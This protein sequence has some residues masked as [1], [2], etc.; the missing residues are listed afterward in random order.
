MIVYG[1]NQEGHM[2]AQCLP[3]KDPPT[4]EEQLKAFITKLAGAPACRLAIAQELYRPTWVD[5]NGETHRAE[6]G[7][8]L[9]T[10]EQ[11]LRLIGAG[12]DQ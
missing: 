4:T 1:R 7:E 12:E 11:F 2:I 6:E 9:I 3:D 5:E 8:G 10:K